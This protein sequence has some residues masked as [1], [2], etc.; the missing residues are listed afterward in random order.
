MKSMRK[1]DPQKDAQKII[2]SI[3]SYMESYNS[4]DRK[5]LLNKLRGVI[6]K[7]DLPPAAIAAGAEGQDNL[8]A[9]ISIDQQLDAAARESRERE[10]AAWEKWR[11]ASE[12]CDAVKREYEYWKKA[13]E[14][15]ETS[16]RPLNES[17]RQATELLS[18][19]VPC[20]TKADYEKRVTVLLNKQRYLCGSLQPGRWGE[21]LTSG[22]LDQ[23]RLPGAGPQSSKT[24]AVPSVR[25]KNEDFEPAERPLDAVK[26][27][28]EDTKALIKVTDD[29]LRDLK[30][31]ENV[32]L[33]YQRL[34][35][36]A[37]LLRDFLPA[38][39][40]LQQFEDAE[41]RAA[42]AVKIGVTLAD[43][44]TN[45]RCLDP[46]MRFLWLFPDDDAYWESLSVRLDF[47]PAETECPGLYYTHGTDA[48]FCV[49]PGRIEK[50]NEEAQ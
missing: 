4:Y 37:S 49:V 3:H 47:I 24:D 30:R 16:V 9:K 14:Y 5:Y 1:P 32:R 6:K 25:S 23:L 15:F 34:W 2:T 41:D 40:L 36:N 48:P 28:D 43:A 19:F 26:A 46:E 39:E 8:G 50:N 20:Q 13:E 45:H 38:I 29:Y 33:Q 35:E 31:M 12:E 42:L 27:Y 11:N 17:F 10:R 22:R 44:V 21:C 18:Y 7:F